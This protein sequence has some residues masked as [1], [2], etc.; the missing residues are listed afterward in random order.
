METHVDVAVIG[1]GQAGLSAGYY[2]RRLGREAG[3]DFVILDHAPKPGGA[4]QFRWPSLTLST[5]NAVH[6]LPGMPFTDVLD[7]SAPT[8]VQAA[9]AVPRYYAE[10]ERRFDLPVRRPEHVRVVCDH[11]DHRVDDDPGSRSGPLTVET[12][13]G[14]L[15]VRGIVNA[16]GTWEHPFIPR[17]RG[18]ELFLGRQLHTRDYTSAAEFAGRHVVVVGGGI[19]AVQLLDEISRVTSTTW[20]TRREPQFRDTPYTAAEG[21]ASVAVVEDRVRRGLPPG[22]VVSVTGLPLTPALRAARERGALHRLPMFDEIT[23]DGVRWADGGFRRADVILWCTGFRSA[24]DHLAPLRLR[25]P[26]GGIT[27]DGRLATRVAADRRVHLL[28]Y[29]PS[30]STIGAN[31]GGRAAAAELIEHLTGN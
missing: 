20:V 13:D 7:D 29:G 21:R 2:L 12:G 31:R 17:C 3:I 27:M 25:G 4:W 18:A 11:G 5:V 9:D 30:A 10:Y 15:T 19:S 23:P 14:G 28:G 6:D 24:L 16:T 26:G 1:A 22:S 8:E